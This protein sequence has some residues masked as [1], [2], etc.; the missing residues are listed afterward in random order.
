MIKKASLKK[1]VETSFGTKPKT[2]N[3]GEPSNIPPALEL[4]GSAFEVEVREQCASLPQA[5]GDYLDMIT[6]CM[7]GIRHVKNQ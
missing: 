5:L 1:I 4:C 3:R 6:R 7:D 2:K